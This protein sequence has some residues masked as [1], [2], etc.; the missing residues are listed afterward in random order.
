M[1]SVNLQSFISSTERISS[2]QEGED[3]QQLERWILLERPTA[4]EIQRGIG[5][6]M[7]LSSPSE[8][9]L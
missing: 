3:L 7:L 5:S 2:V 6:V 9:S 8:V 4:A 1:L